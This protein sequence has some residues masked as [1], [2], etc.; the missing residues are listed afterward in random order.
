MFASIWVIITKRYNNSGT[1]PFL[2][3]GLNTFF[4]LATDLL[5]YFRCTLQP[6]VVNSCCHYC[7]KTWPISIAIYIFFLRGINV[8][9]FCRIFLGKPQN[10]NIGN[11]SWGKG[12]KLVHESRRKRGILVYAFLLKVTLENMSFFSK[13][14]KS[15]TI[16]VII[17]PRKPKYPT[18]PFYITFTS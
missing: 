16:K 5:Y 4:F 1:F 6:L 13:F 7:G 12:S 15:K 9:Q 14:L 2:A 17:L 18:F 8:F 3:V 10:E 11:K